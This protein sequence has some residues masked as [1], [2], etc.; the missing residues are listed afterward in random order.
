M[1]FFGQM[2][3]SEIFFGRRVKKGRS[4]IPAKIWFPRL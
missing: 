1:K 2:Q 3:K 4:K